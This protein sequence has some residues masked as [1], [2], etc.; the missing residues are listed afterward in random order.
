MSGRVRKRLWRRGRGKVREGFS[1]LFHCT[2][3]TYHLPSINNKNDKGRG[4]D[5]EKEVRREEKE[6]RRRSCR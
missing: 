4:M 2:F 1:F 3:T 6:E 5:E